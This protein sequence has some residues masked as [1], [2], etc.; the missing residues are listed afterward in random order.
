MAF[1][2][3][4]GAFAHLDAEVSHAAIADGA[5]GDEGEDE[6][7]E[8]G[9]DDAGQDD[10]ALHGREDGGDGTDEDGEH[11]I[12]IEPGLELAAAG[13][14]E[15]VR[16]EAGF[17]LL[18]DVIEDDATNDGAEDGEGGS[19]VGLEG[20]IGG[21]D[22]EESIHGAGQR[23]ARRVEGCQEKETSWTE[24]HQS[25]NEFLQTLLV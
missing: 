9:A 10:E 6:G 15:E 12:V 21:E 2:I 14:G 19:K 23:N 1:E 11:A 20:L 17:A 16:E 3:G 8:G 4:S 13:T 18:G 22:E 25:R 24:A 5:G 7:A